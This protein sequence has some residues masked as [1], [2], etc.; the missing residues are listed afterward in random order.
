[1]NVTIVGP[2]FD[3]SGYAQTLRT[4]ALGL[5]KQGKTVRVIPRDWS[6]LDSGISG[7]ER[8]NLIKICGDGILPD[9]PIIQINIAQEFYP[10]PGRVNI[11]MS[12]LE[13]D[14]IPKQWVE[15]CNKMSQVWVPST[16]NKETFKESG[17]IEEKIK[18][19]PIGIDTTR[20]SPEALPIKLPDLEDHF[21]FIS[22]FEW[23]PRKGFDILINA[24][25]DEFN[26]NEKVALLIKTYS[27]SNFDEEGKEIR[28]NLRTIIEKKKKNQYPLIKLITHGF[29]P[30]QLPS[31]YTAG[32]CYVIPTRG[33]GWNLPALESMACQIPVITTNWSAHLDFIN[34][35][36][37]FLINIEGL[38][39]IPEFQTRND[40]V[41]KGMKWSIPSYADTRKLLRFT[42]DNPL[43]VKKK[44][45]LARED[46]VQW[47]DVT[48]M[49][50]NI[51]P[52]LE[53]LGE[54]NE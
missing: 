10:I 33:E 14:R 16:F 48:N 12:M 51:K 34:E 9:G 7:E 36:N 18:V 43:I 35:S 49:M 23:V 8:L 3:A 44:G 13:C 28:S 4:I 19:I 11:G 40:M 2:T 45:E 53:K 6:K 38:E 26:S 52:I 54:K 39:N 50:E 27:G 17:V 15:K 25:L 29:S 24:F 46:V 30:D 1:M 20:F 31:F 21:V 47:W 41:Y 37:G 22:N 42:F 32:N 5:H